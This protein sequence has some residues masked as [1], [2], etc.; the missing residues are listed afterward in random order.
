MTTNPRN[1][2]NPRTYD[3]IENAQQNRKADNFIK[4]LSSPWIYYAQR[5]IRNPRLSPRSIS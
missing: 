5:I 3:L 1:N 2:D 4:I